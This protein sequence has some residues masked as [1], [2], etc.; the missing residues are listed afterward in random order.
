MCYICSGNPNQ[1][2]ATCVP[3]VSSHGALAQRRAFMSASRSAKLALSSLVCLARKRSSVIGSASLTAACCPPPAASPRSA[4]RQEPKP[5]APEASPAPRCGFSGSSSVAAVQRLHWCCLP[6][7]RLAVEHRNQSSR[8]SAPA[9]CS[10]H[11]SLQES[12]AAYT[13]ACAVFSNCSYLLLHV[14]YLSLFILVIN[15]NKNFFIR[16]DVIA[17]PTC[18]T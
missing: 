2:G 12:R 6:Q 16:G 4:R 11:W 5:S 9:V 3:S 7:G 8:T 13:A 14:K 1:G 17:K 10:G 15:N 18:S